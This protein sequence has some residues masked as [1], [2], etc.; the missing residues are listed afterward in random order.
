MLCLKLFIIIIIIIIISESFRYLGR[1]FD[2]E[3]SNQTI[4]S[5]LTTLIEE[6]MSDIDFKPLHPKNK[7]TTV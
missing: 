4:K 6:M 5:E 1:Y 3:M 7:S 2:F